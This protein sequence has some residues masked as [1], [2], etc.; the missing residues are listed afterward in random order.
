MH[1]I[2]TDGYDH[3]QFQHTVYERQVET[4]LNTTFT[5]SILEICSTEPE[6]SGEYLCTANNGFS[7]AS[8]TSPTNLT[9]IPGML[10]M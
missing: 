3:S 8:V 10:C 5:E 6:D 2:S 7:S 4:E 9:V 1:M